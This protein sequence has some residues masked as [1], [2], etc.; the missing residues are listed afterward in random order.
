MPSKSCQTNIYKSFLAFPARRA[1]FPAMSTPIEIESAEEKRV[2]L[3]KMA[4]SIYDSP[5]VQELRKDRER[6][7]W[8]QAN[9]SLC[10]FI[11]DG[12]WTKDNLREGIDSARA[13]YAGLRSSRHLTATHIST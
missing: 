10:K 3:R 1:I 2:G 7:D 4:E 11:G 6:L 13:E 9:W 12:E 5:L 8:I